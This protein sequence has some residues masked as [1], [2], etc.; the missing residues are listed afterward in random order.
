MNKPSLIRR[1]TNIEVS[2][3][4]EFINRSN[5]NW[6]HQFNSLH[7][8]DYDFKK[9][10]SFPFVDNFKIDDIFLYEKFLKVIP[11][12]ISCCYNFYGPGRFS[13]IQVAKVT[14]EST[15][16]PHRDYGFI[17]LWSH[18]IHLPLQTNDKVFFHLEKDKMN[19]KLGELVEVNNLKTHYVT[20]CNEK[21]FDR[22]HLI[23]DYMPEE[24]YRMYGDV[25]Q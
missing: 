22:I 4:L 12:I 23:F 10:Y 1:L 16:N 24:Y 19:L 14:P 25:F 13:K 3:L 9:V 8:R 15:V 21:E 6:D 11:D 17:F 7:G 5:I 18:R 2:P 20:N